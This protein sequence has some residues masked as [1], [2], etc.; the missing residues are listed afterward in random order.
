[1]QTMPE[2]QAAISKLSRRELWKLVE[3]LDEK[4]NQVW[5]REMEEDAA[6]GR[7]DKFSHEAREDV[8]AGR[9][10]PMEEVLRSRS[11]IPPHRRTRR[12]RS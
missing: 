12:R 9:T 7:L 4:R 6:A 8:R 2:I 5:D 10:Y 3:W 11:K 1:M